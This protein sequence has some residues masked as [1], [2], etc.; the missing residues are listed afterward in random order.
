MDKV[1]KAAALMF[2]TIYLYDFIDTLSTDSSQVFDVIG[3]EVSKITYL[4]FLLAVCVSFLT[5][6]FTKQMEKRDSENQPVSN[7]D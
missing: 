7:S 4:A 6:G 2:G 5:Y 1:K 3:F